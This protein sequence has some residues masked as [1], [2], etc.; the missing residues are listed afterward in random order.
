MASKPSRAKRAISEYAAH[1]FISRFSR[2]T[3]CAFVSFCGSLT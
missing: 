3:R 1:G 2:S